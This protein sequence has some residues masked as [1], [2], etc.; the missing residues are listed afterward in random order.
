[1]GERRW[2]LKGREW[3]RKRG[4]GK[5]KKEGGGVEGDQVCDVSVLYRQCEA[6]SRTLGAGRQLRMRLH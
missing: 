4:Q 1:M 6:T 2:N 3:I 5:G